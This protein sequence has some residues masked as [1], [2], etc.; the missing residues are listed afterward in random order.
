MNINIQ[1]INKN[2]TGKIN[3]QIDSEVKSIRYL[4][5]KT[6]KPIITKVNPNP[7]VYSANDT[8]LLTFFKSK[9]FI[10]N[11]KF[12]LELA[13]TE[14]TNRM[15]ESIKRKVAVTI[16]RVGLNCHINARIVRTAPIIVV[17][18]IIQSLTLIFSSDFSTFNHH[19]LSY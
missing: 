3:A 6:E 19:F 15:N 9:F 5:P 16:P 2:V 14:F 1:A 10:F 17:L 13:D 11:S 7:N 4:Y 12:A 18:K 8:N